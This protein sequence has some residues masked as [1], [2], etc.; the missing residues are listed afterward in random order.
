MIA[1]DRTEALLSSS[2]KI[3]DGPTRR[4]IW[5]AWNWTRVSWSADVTHWKLLSVSSEYSRVTCVVGINVSTEPI[6]CWCRCCCW[7]RRRKP[8]ANFR[9][10]GFMVLEFSFDWMVHACC[11]HSSS[12][13]SLNIHDFACVAWSKSIVSFPRSFV[14]SRS[15]SLW[16][17][18][19]WRQDSSLV[20]KNTFNGI[21]LD[22]G[23]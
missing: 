2:G 6:S 21:V 15:S 9:T 23:T 17:E 5:C 4:C 11:R 20:G 7:L 14:F 12:A 22:F 10:L 19:W 18:M 16:D 8:D 1:V 3:A 13:R